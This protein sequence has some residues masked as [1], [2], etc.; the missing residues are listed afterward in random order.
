MGRNNLRSWDAELYFLKWSNR[1]AYSTNTH[2]L[3]SKLVSSKTLRLRYNPAI[4]PQVVT[5][6]VVL[7]SCYDIYDLYLQSRLDWKKLSSN[8]ESKCEY[9]IWE[10]QAIDI[11]A[12]FVV[13]CEFFSW[14]MIT[15]VTSRRLYDWSKKFRSNSKFG[16]QYFTWNKLRAT[17]I[18]TSKPI[19]YSL[20]RGEKMK[21]R[22]TKGVFLF[23]EH[24][25][26]ELVS[27]IVISVFLNTSTIRKL[28]K[29]AT[30]ALIHTQR[31]QSPAPL[32]ILRDSRQENP[33]SRHCA[34]CA[35]FPPYIYEGSRIAFSLPS[36]NV[37]G[38]A[39]SSSETSSTG[40]NIALRL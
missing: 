31:T 37:C 18:N 17:P 35:T 19:R 39:G 14:I 2:S 3:D 6:D 7:Q 10:F 5:W 11:N 33:G 32:T 26:I 38:R 30:K 25:T 8:S 4:D 24:R 12:G 22:D 27:F 28:S 34:T 13:R 9:L 29:F 40:R 16:S 21:E 1:I 20:R 15:N 23:R 36:R